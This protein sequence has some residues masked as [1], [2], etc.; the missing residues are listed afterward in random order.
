M[1]IL[2]I[3]EINMLSGGIGTVLTDQVNFEKK[4]L[5]IDSNLYNLYSNTK[6]R[7]NMCVEFEKILYSNKFDIII[8]HGFYNYKYIKL[9]KTILKNKLNYYIKPHGSFSKIV[10][11][12]G[13]LK[14]AFA[15]QIFFNKFLKCSSGIIFLSENEEL[16]SYFIFKKE[17]IFYQNNGIYKKDVVL[18]NKSKDI[19]LFYLGRFDFKYKGLKELFKSIEKI[20]EQLKQQFIEIE[21]YGYGNFKEEKKVKKYINKVN[22][23]NLKLKNKIFDIEKIEMLKR[24]NIMILPS[25]TEGM[26]MGVLEALLFGIPCIL[27][28]ETNMLDDILKN[29]CGWECKRDELEKTILLAIS[30][31]KNKKE[32]YIK[33]CQKLAEKFCFENT[34]FQLKYIETYRE[35]LKKKKL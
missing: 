20:K 28:K 7:K 29:A 33:N 3:A 22:L 15:N 17:K 4:F 25:K 11:K 16:N 14:K 32:I 27:T 21:I 12:T 19:K 18:E 23:E 6:D 35:M 24:N 8:F 9:Y 2:H 1:K 5:N 10:Q 26:P 13:Y 31:Y 30:D 34:E